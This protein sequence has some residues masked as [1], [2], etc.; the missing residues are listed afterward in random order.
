[1]SERK[2]I[3][4]SVHFLNEGFLDTLQFVTDPNTLKDFKKEALKI[5]ETMNE[6]VSGEA[7]SGIFGSILGAKMNRATEKIEKDDP[8]KVYIIS[9][10]Y[11]EILKAAGEKQGVQ[12]SVFPLL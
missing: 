3:F 6:I 11:K 8:N 10:T 7:T 12:R 2:P 9:F 1:M 5:T 4:E